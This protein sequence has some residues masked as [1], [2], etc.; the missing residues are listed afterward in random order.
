MGELLSP[1][2]FSPSP[3][4]F[5][6]LAGTKYIIR[7]SFAFKKRQNWTCGRQVSSLNGNSTMESRLCFGMAEDFRLPYLVPLPSRFDALRS[8]STLQGGSL[9]QRSVEIGLVVVE[10]RP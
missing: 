2:N 4:S 10:F 3:E 5:R 9:R 8:P 6:R 7:R 1:V